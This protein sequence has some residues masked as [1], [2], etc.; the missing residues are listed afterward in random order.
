MPRQLY[1]QLMDN[2]LQQPF[3]PQ[4]VPP[5]ASSVPQQPSAAAAVGFPSVSSDVQAQLPKLKVEVCDSKLIPFRNP[6]TR[7]NVAGSTEVRS[8]RDP[9]VV[10]GRS[11]DSRGGQVAPEETPARGDSVENGERQRRLLVALGIR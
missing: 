3:P 9:G 8:M 7:S 1:R 4:P 10:R 6:F 11:S 5:P 2:Q